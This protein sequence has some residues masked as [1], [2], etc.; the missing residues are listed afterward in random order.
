MTKQTMIDYWIK[1]AEEDAITAETLFTSKRYVP[2][3][4]FCHLFTEKII[5]GIIVKETGEPAPYGHKLSRL[6]SFTTISFSKDQ[7]DL[8][9]ELTGFQISARYEDYKFQLSKKATVTYTKDYLDK[10]KEL[11]L[12]LQKQV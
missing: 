6:A 3:L 8:L 12:W 5:K 10:S 9:D 7:L 2:C 4:F 11:Y 1:G